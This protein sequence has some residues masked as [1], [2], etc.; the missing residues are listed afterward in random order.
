MFLCCLLCTEWVPIGPQPTS[1]VRTHIG[2]CVDTWAK[3]C[4][5][6]WVVYGVQSGPQLGPK[7]KP[8]W[9]HFGYGVDT[10]AKLGLCFWAVYRVY[11]QLG[12]QLSSSVGPT[13]DM[14]WMCGLNSVW[15]YVLF[16][17]YGVGP[18]WA[19][20]NEP[21]WALLWIWRGHVG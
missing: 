7:H 19:P 17:G 6:F 21:S 1:P 9:P 4:L 14:V 11:S 18:N 3:L 20:A 10:W 12:P 16:T 2:Y 15:I 5:G 13:L 8:N